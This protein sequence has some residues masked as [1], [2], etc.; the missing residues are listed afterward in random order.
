M[1]AHGGTLYHSPYY[2]MPYLPG[3]PTVLTSH[4]VIP[5][6]FPEYFTL[7]QRVAYR[8]A[9]TSAIRTASK[10]IVVSESTKADLTRLFRAPPERVRVIPHGVDPR[11][12]RASGPAI[13]A[14]RKK[15]RLPDRYLLYVGTNKPHKNLV[16][17]VEA[18]GKALREYRLMPSCMLVIA[19]YWDNRYPEALTRTHE[20]GLS[21]NIIFAGPIE[22]HDLAPLYAGASLFIFPS[23]YEGF[24]FPVLEAMACGTPVMCSATSGLI[25]VAGQAALLFD[26]HNPSE[27]ARHIADT[28]SS[29]ERLQQLREAG[30]SQASR[31]T[32]ERTA[33][34]TL[35]V[36]RELPS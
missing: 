2:L 8:I 11:F 35:A 1:K 24:G 23:L 10:V 13:D 15:Y 20:L 14:V 12:T 30:F 17:L 36:Y 22:D 4:D 27:M 34:E 6:I 29:P 3:I 7:W 5:L 28:L 9:N 18:W 21:G 26:P 25:E 16:R 32:W 33:G 31:F 19:G